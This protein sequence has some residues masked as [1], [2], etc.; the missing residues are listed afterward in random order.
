M[1]H[2]LVWITHKRPEILAAVNILSKVTEET[3]TKENIKTKNTIIKHFTDS[4]ARKL[5]MIKLH[6][7]SK[8]I[9]VYYDEFFA[10]N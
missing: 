2:K 8:H 6:L 1:R 4:H 7:H 5:T 9:I 3:L 10:G